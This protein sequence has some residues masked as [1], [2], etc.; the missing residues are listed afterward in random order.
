MMTAFRQVR[1]ALVILLAA[2]ATACDFGK[3]SG[4]TAP[5]QSAVPFAIVDLTIGTGTE[6]KAAG[7]SVTTSY[8]AWLYS[9]TAPD[10]KGTQIDQ[11]QLSFVLGANQVIPGFEQGV[12]GMKVGGT[13]RVTVPPSL[14]Y[15]A[16]GNQSI[17]PNA[18][19]VF[20]IALTSATAPQ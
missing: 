20:D 2:G 16:S 12:T 7:T 9:E 13:R 6:A 18:A 10:H 4:P 5:D 11:N 8:A 1:L 19:L 17:P 15:G 14:A 3:V